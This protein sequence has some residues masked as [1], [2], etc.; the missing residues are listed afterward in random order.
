[1]N[2]WMNEWMNEWNK[3]TSK[4]EKVKTFKG[5]DLWNDCALY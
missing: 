3:E 4:N 5:Q 1:M 2:K